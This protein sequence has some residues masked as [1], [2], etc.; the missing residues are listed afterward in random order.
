MRVPGITACSAEQPIRPP[1]W[2]DLPAMPET[3]KAELESQKRAN[4]MAL[5]HFEP[6]SDAVLL[7]DSGT[8]L[9]VQSA[10]LQARSEVCKFSWHFQPPCTELHR[11]REYE[12]PAVLRC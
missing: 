6:S 8:Q 3:V 1:H 5:D 7:L 9:T 11:G 12:R 10:F 4:A 2:S